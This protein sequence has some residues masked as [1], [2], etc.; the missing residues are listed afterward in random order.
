MIRRQRSTT[1]TT[2]RRERGQ[3]ITEF[4]IAL[5][6]F[7]MFVFVVIQLGLLFVAYYSETRMARE[8]A[9]WLAIHPM[10]TDLEVAQHVYDTML[11]GLVRG[12]APPTNA[13]KDTANSTVA[14]TEYVIGNMHARFTSCPSAPCANSNVKRGTSQTLYVQM[15]YDVSSLLFLP[16]TFHF[17]SLTTK[18]PT[19]LPPY[20]V[21]V[22]VE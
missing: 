18:L 12:N 1:A 8:T 3:A 20:K 7:A 17:G 6:M 21:S 5:P 16:S 13:N 10:S 4:A 15:S 14:D 22:M 19:K 2:A 11:P 9:R